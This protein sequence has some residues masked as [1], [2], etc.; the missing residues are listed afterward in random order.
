M[1]VF[2]HNVKHMPWKWDDDKNAE[3][4][5]H[6]SVYLR[7]DLQHMFIKTVKKLQSPYKDFPSS[8][9]GHTHSRTYVSFANWF[10]KTYCGNY[11]VYSCM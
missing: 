5:G 10:S 7:H 11:K 3:N 8:G 9:G 4:Y 1:C 6:I 2:A